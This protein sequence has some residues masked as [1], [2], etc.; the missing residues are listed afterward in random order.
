MK[1]TLSIEYSKTSRVLVATGDDVTLSRADLEH[2]T[3]R[4]TIDGQDYDLLIVR[5]GNATRAIAVPVGECVWLSAPEHWRAID[6]EP[7]IIKEWRAV[8]LINGFWQ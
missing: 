3:P 1:A 6:Y 4:A 5:G 7:T 2:D 8:E